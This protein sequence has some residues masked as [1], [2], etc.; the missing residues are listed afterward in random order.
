MRPRTW[1]LLPWLVV[2][3]ANVLGIAER[4]VDTAANYPGEGYAGCRPGSCGGCLDVHR[5]E[6]EVRSTCADAIEDDDCAGCVCMSCEPELIDCRADPG[7]SAIWECLRATRCDLSERAEGSCLQLCSSIIQASGG[8]TGPAFRAAAELRSCAASSAC[9]TCLA[10]QVQRAARTCTQSNGCLDCDACFDQCLCSGERFGDCQGLCATDDAPPPA[11][12]ED[13]AC[14]DCTSCFDACA[15][16]GGSYDSCVT[17]C[18]PPSDTGTDQEPAPDPP[19][20]TECSAQSNCASC[21]DCVS[22]CTCSTANTTEACQELCAPQAASDQ[23]IEDPRGVDSSCEGCQSCVAQCTCKGS[24]LE[25]CRRMCQA[26][27]CCGAPGGCGSALGDCLCT[28]SGAECY[29][30]TYGSCASAGACESCAC[31]QCPA[32]RGM[33]LDIVGCQ[34]TFDCMRATQCQGSA[35]LERCRGSDYAPEAFAYAEALWACHRGSDCGCGTPP[36]PAIACPT[37]QGAVQCEPYAGNVGIQ[38]CCS[39]APS[40][41]TAPA[42]A[43]QALVDTSSP[44]GLQLSVFVRGARS[45]EPRTQRNLPRYAP[46]ETCPDGTVANAPYSGALLKGCCREDGTCGY[47]DDITGLGCLSSTVFGRGALPCP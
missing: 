34:E 12:S 25:S 8:A 35:C 13:D 45:C 9:W 36:P 41:A 11:C 46:L 43:E 24:S 39:A 10:P 31:Q 17:Q 29:L 47:Y 30:Q 42:A 6:C 2:A 4:E 14:A 7:C 3:C 28:G 1:L 22:Q 21:T 23:C 38:A 33:C 19:A 37:A 27:D 16:G 40:A 18:A 20:A 32:E 15:C 26:A 5:Q 44:C